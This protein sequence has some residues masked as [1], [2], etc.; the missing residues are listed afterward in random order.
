MADVKFNFT[1]KTVLI[2]G[3]A[4]GVGRE[5]AIQFCDAGAQIIAV[6]RDEESL[7]ISDECMC[8]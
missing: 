8:A 3:A 5:M 6:D 2:S 7:E 1:G 4:R